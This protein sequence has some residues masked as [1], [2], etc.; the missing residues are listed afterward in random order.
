MRAF[1]TFFLIMSASSVRAALL[2]S[3]GNSNSPLRMPTETGTVQSGD[4]TTGWTPKPTRAP[5]FVNEQDQVVEL[6]RR[7]R[8]LTDTTPWVNDQTCGWVAQTSSR[9]I[10]CASDFTCATNSANLVACVSGTFSPF[11]RVCMDYSAVQQ[12]QCSDVGPETGCCDDRASPAC[13]TWVWTGK[14]ARSQ[15]GCAARSTIYSVMDIPQF[16][17]DS[18]T[19]T[20]SSSTKPSSTLSTKTTSTANVVSSSSQSTQTS[21]APTAGSATGDSLTVGN[22]TSTTTNL[23]PIIAGS[24]GGLVGLIL[25][26]VLLCC[27]LRRRRNKK[28]SSTVNKSNTKSSTENNTTVNYNM[29]Q[30]NQYTTATTSNNNAWHHDKT[31]ADAVVAEKAASHGI[32]GGGLAAAFC[33]GAGSRKTKKDKNARSIPQPGQ[34]DSQ[35]PQGQKGNEEHHHHHH[36]HFDPSTAPSSITARNS[37]AGSGH[38]IVAAGPGFAQPARTLSFETIPQS[39]YSQHPAS[40][41]PYNPYAAGGGISSGG[42]Q[43]IAPAPAHAQVQAYHPP[44]PTPAAVPSQ[45][46]HSSPLGI[47]NNSPVP[48]RSELNGSPM[49]ATALGQYQQHVQQPQ[50]CHHQHQRPLQHFDQQQQHFQQCCQHPAPSH[51][52]IYDPYK[53]GALQA[54]AGLAATQPILSLNIGG[55]TG[56]V[57]A[58]NKSSPASTPASGLASPSPMSS[59]ASTMPSLHQQP[60]GIGGDVAIHPLQP[61]PAHS[62][63]ASMYSSFTTMNG[64]SEVHLGRSQDGQQQPPPH[65]SCCVASHHQKT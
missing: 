46:L 27:C 34:D 16:V 33:C 63:R 32:G 36:Y 59:A 53:P 54:Q 48:M 4:T 28:N 52:R 62:A 35:P 37:D 17:L 42:S 14:P 10:L 7:Q 25:I 6:L 21:T 41:T 45:F 49:A 57:E 38:G 55:G 29:S 12:G 13:A 60:G 23:V 30:E 8:Q 3:W 31:M 24:V 18:L 50:A 1:S 47:S 22:Q 40:L 20:T 11:F 51:D 64:Q 56:L 39:A 58:A 19:R 2:H 61:P 9:A 44:V 26:L 15:Y 65:C 43:T 5:G